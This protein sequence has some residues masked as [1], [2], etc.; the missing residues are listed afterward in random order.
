M[1]DDHK[2]KLC[3]WVRSAPVGSKGEFV[4]QVTGFTN[5]G[6]IVRCAENKRW[7]RTDDD[8]EPADAE[9]LVYGF[10]GEA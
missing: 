3:D 6:Y 1:S 10:T 9:R 4:G 8:L 5:D 2:F 7:G